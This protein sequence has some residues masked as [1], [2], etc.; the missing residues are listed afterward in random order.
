MPCLLPKKTQKKICRDNGRG[1]TVDEAAR[2]SRR[3]NLFARVKECVLK[4]MDMGDLFS[5]WSK[6]KTPAPPVPVVV[7]ASLVQV[8][9]V[10]CTM[11]PGNRDTVSCRV[12][13][14]EEEDVDPMIVR[15]LANSD[16]TTVY[17]SIPKQVIADAKVECMDD[18][19]VAGCY[20]NESNDGR[21]FLNAQSVRRIAPWTEKVRPDLL[22]RDH[23]VV[24][25]D[26]GHMGPT[27]IIYSGSFTAPV[28]YKTFPGLFRMAEWSTT[29]LTWINKRKVEE[30]RLQMSFQQRQWQTEQ[31]ARSNPAPISMTMK[32]WDN[33]CRQLPGNGLTKSMDVWKAI[34]AV[35]PIPFYAMVAVNTEY[36]RN[37]GVLPLFTFAMQ[38]D[39]RAYFEQSCVKM[40]VEMMRKLVPKS[41]PAAGGGQA[42]IVNVSD[43][44]MVPVGPNWQY[45]AMTADPTNITTAEEVVEAKCAKLLFAVCQKDTK[46]PPS[47]ETSSKPPS[48][49]IKLKAK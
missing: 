28:T 42:D 19:L 23:V 25:Q 18:V 45:Y 1:K 15:A 4:M 17:V 8:R 35:N 48:K 37:D 38:W 7:A 47:S 46:A 16:G 36:A 22:A 44:G 39:L 5:I 27:F 29:E 34:M 14:T 33:Q 43:T 26:G 13:V 11:A 10:L 20:E 24:P 21:V 12:F 31:E 41:A 2:V 32:I 6:D 49:R 3:L 40:S 30:R 9:G